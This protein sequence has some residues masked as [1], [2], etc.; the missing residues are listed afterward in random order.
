MPG[1]IKDISGSNRMRFTRPGTDP[2]NLNLDPNQVVF[3][4][5][6][7]GN[8]NILDYG[9]NPIASSPVG[10]GTFSYTL[11]TWSLGYAPMVI[12]VV[13]FADQSDAYY[14]PLYA[15]SLNHAYLSSSPSGLV[16]TKGGGAASVIRW[17]AFRF[18]I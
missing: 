17:T 12:A 5:E 2:N 13:K 10:S 18:A 6:A 1:F 3:D 15:A 11:R 4:S 7:I 16:L 9:E 14:T 8:L